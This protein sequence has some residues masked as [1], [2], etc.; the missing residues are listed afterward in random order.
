MIRTYLELPLAAGAAD[1][2]VAFF[3]R[4][5]ILSTAAAQEGCLGAE[6]TITTD[7]TSAIV[8]ALW[9]DAGAYELWTSR[10]DRA[11]LADELST[12]L[13]GAIGAATV[14]RVG[15]VAL[16]APA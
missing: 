11:E 8:T 15:R 7:G 6:L 14:G 9:S 1:G 10:S 2:L 12:F 13:D 16:S 5:A 4:E 3:D